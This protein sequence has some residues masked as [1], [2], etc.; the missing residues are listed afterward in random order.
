MHSGG[1]T[2]FQPCARKGVASR[3]LH[4][5]ALNMNRLRT[6][7]E[8]Y[9]GFVSWLLMLWHGFRKAGAV[10]VEGAS[11]PSS[12]IT[13]SSTVMP[14][15][16]RYGHL[17]RLLDDVHVAPA[18]FSKLKLLNPLECYDRALRTAGAS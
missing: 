8:L 2:V 16:P 12:T 3:V 7:H 11:S 6:C 1:W 18:W 15:A 5:G 9:H 14:H 4:A 13:C 17:L 10:P